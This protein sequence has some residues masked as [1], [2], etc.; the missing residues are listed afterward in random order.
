VRTDAARAVHIPKHLLATLTAESWEV[1]AHCRG[2]AA[3]LWDDNLD[4]AGSETPLERR[5][6][7][8]KAAAVCATCPALQACAAA[9]TPQDAGIWAGRLVGA[10][11]CIDCGFPMTRHQT[12]RRPGTRRHAAHGR[13]HSCFKH[14]RKHPEMVGA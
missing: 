2:P 10:D 12:P 11:Q 14:A 6:R 4:G 3:H 13:C 1:Q 9:V 7:H 5:A 8:A